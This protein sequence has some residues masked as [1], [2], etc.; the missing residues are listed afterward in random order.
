MIVKHRGSDEKE[1]KQNWQAH[2]PNIGGNEDDDGERTEP[3]VSN[4]E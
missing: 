3:G 4:G 2:R 1:G